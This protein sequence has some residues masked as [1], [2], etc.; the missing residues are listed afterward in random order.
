[1]QA[2]SA[3][4]KEEKPAPPPLSVEDSV[5][6]LD[7]RVGTI[8]AVEKHPDADS[9]YVETVD[10]GEEEPRT[11]VSGLVK[12]VSEDQLLNRNVLVLANL[13]PR[14]MRGIKSF[15]MLLCASN[16]EHT[17]VEPLT[18]PEGAVPGERLR[19]CGGEDGETPEP[20]PATGNALQKKKIWERSQ[21][22]FATDA[23][24]AP[25]FRGIPFVTS[26]G[27]VT[28]TIPNGTIS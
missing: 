16:E 26:A 17:E 2:F 7:I 18:P 4:T 9:L 24:G 23:D 27:P 14:N 3:A 5:G 21:P 13:K 8:T 1:M 28:P 20:E 25:S 15:G 22:D 19:F 12:Y 11:I 10:M 6:K